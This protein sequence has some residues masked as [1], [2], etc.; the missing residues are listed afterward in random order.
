MKKAVAIGFVI[1]GTGSWFW[2]QWNGFLFAPSNVSAGEGHIV[3]AIFLVGAAIVW[4]LRP[5]I[6]D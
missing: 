5:S 2:P 6:S 4:F 3:G 1:A